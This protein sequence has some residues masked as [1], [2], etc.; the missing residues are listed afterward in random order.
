MTTCA[1]EGH[2]PA[3]SAVRKAANRARARSRVAR[4]MCRGIG[5]VATQRLAGNGDR[6]RK[7]DSPRERPWCSEIAARDAAI[8]VKG[9]P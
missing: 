7:V 2:F 3:E 1:R 6:R 8:A 9:R 4:A 5:G